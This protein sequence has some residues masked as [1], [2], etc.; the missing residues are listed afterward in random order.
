MRPILIA[1]GGIGGLTAAIAL[2]KHGIQ[3]RV[4]EARAESTREGA[5]I[6]LGPNATRVLEHLGIATALAPAAVAPECII[7]NDGISGR[8]LTRLPLGAW[9]A[10]RHGAPYWVVHRVAL[11]DVLLAAAQSEPRIAIETGRRISDIS[12]ITSS[13]RIT[14]AFEDGGA[15]DGAA[16]IG[17]DGIWSRVR[18]HVNPAFSLQYAGVSAVRAVVTRDPSWE[19]F[20]ELATGVWLAPD[21]HV[22]HYPVDGGAR[23][24]VVAIGKTAEPADGWHGAVGHD[25]IAARFQRMP[26]EVRAFFEMADEWR[27]WPL[28]ETANGGSWSKGRALLIGDAAHPI[29]PFLAQGGAMAIEDGYEIAAAIAD[30]GCDANAVFANFWRGRRRRV[31]GVQAASAQNGRAYHLT[32]AGALAR[33]AALRSLPGAV[34]MRQYDWIYGYGAVRRT[35][36]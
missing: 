30:E 36:E 7:V 23:I 2:A 14:V 20:G 19:R 32:G 9:M 35:A 33:N 5:G 18:D 22:V 4:L 15:A 10:R 17:A 28:Y 26:R 8:E 1:G 34:F 11:H 6:Q 24:A 27:Q 16:L 3:S 21:A 12:D 31:E 29:M 25:E 13:D